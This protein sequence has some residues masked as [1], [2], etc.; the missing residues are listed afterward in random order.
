MRRPATQGS[1]DP[2]TPYIDVPEDVDSHENPGDELPYYYVTIVE[3]GAAQAPSAVRG[4]ALSVLGV[5]INK[6]PATYCANAFHNRLEKFKH[7]L[8]CQPQQ[9]CV[10]PLGVL[11]CPCPVV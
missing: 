11:H 8:L 3:N 2:S 7:R 9:V 1:L 6:V 4:S 5:T 10:L